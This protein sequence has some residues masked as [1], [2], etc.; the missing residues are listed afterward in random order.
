M[1]ASLFIIIAVYLTYKIWKTI[2]W[3]LDNKIAKVTA[4]LSSTLAWGFF[5]AVNSSSSAILR[6]VKSKTSSWAAKAYWKWKEWIWNKFSD[7]MKN[8]TNER[9]DNSNEKDN[10]NDIKNQNRQTN[11]DLNKQILEQEQF[12]EVEEDMRDKRNNFE[13]KIERSQDNRNDDRFDIMN[14][15]KLSEIIEQLMNLENILKWDDKSMDSKLSNTVLDNLEHAKNWEFDKIKSIVLTDEDKKNEKVTNLV[16]WHNKIIA[17]NKKNEIEKSKEIEVKDE[18]DS[19]VKTIKDNE[20]KQKEEKKE[21]SNV[22]IINN[23]I[24][25]EVAKD[26]K[27]SK[28]NSNNKEKPEI[29]NN[30]KNIFTQSDNTKKD[31]NSKKSNIVKEIIKVIP[32]NKKNTDKKDKKDK[33]E[34]IIEK[35]KII[36]K[37]VLD[38]NISSKLEKIEDSIHSTSDSIKNSIKNKNS[39]PIIQKEN[40]S[41]NVTKLELEKFLQFV[42]TKLNKKELALNNQVIWK[43]FNKDNINMNVTVVNNLKKQY[44][45]ISDKFQNNPVIYQQTKNMLNKLDYIHQN[46]KWEMKMNKQQL[47]NLLSASNKDIKT[48]LYF[49]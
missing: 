36:T 16:N 12:N 20:S 29:V 30:I 31:D 49:K 21:K 10:V 41:N 2:F 1:F 22:T 8:N 35:D 40:S 24:K 46:M 42:S 33:K 43:S 45:K 26:N 44:S 19:N 18:I 17:D 11:R 34:T 4:Q 39:K 48:M 6:T 7:M 38:S 23:N 37:K 14:Q 5:S 3:V 25:Q 27:T 47:S 15:N 32:D 28:T 13:N 9:F